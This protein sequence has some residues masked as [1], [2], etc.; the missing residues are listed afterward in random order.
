M[1]R[2]GVAG[3]RTRVG[4]TGSM[5]PLLLVG[6]PLACGSPPT[7][8]PMFWAL[9]KQGFVRERDAP[10]V[11]Q[12]VTEAD[13]VT[14]SL[15]TLYLK[16]VADQEFAIDEL[17]EVRQLLVYAEVYDSPE[18]LD[19]YRTVIFDGDVRGEDI[20]VD[21]V[22]HTIYGPLPFTGHPLRVELYVV[23]LDKEGNELGAKV[24]SSIGTAASVAQPQAAPA[25]GMGVQLGQV[26]L[27]FNKDDQEL[28]SKM[29]FHPA[30]IDAKVSR[31]PERDPR[32]L[33]LPSDD[34]RVSKV[35]MTENLFVTPARAGN[36]LLVKAES[37]KRRSRTPSQTGP[38]AR[39]LTPPEKPAGEI[40]EASA[41]RYLAV[42]YLTDDSSGKTVYWVP[43][44]K[45][46]YMWWWDIIPTDPTETPDAGGK[47][48][49]LEAGPQG[50]NW[51][52]GDDG[53][54]YTSK[55]YAVLAIHTGGKIADAAKIRAVSV[56]QAQRIQALLQAG[57]Q[58]ALLSSVDK[59]G[60]SAAAQLGALN[61]LEDV[62]V[63]ART[64]PG[65]RTDPA[66]VRELIQSLFDSDK[67]NVDDTYAADSNRAVLKM[68]RSTM[69]DFEL[70][71]DR[72]ADQFLKIKPIRVEAKNAAS[73]C[74]WRDGLFLWKPDATG[75]RADCAK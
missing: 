61:I 26:L 10:L 36:Y 69:P 58:Q 20:F 35:P 24:L 66:F 39:M 34:F 44:Y 50:C 12:Y 9:D 42:D 48:K 60:Q 75:R 64:V 41:R 6:G 62:N 15:N 1:R 16:Y 74:T 4:I 37:K 19:P 29:T 65:Y 63:R 13:V 22:D 59:L 18:S 31:D 67:G 70:W 52:W 51:R 46:G 28:T 7:G 38:N 55:S 21:T 68:I 72:D 71:P 2:R 5:L 3:Q 17:G 54:L 33:G 47:P 49:C 73:I 30:S 45:A 56:K 57:D 25:I 53:T 11:G 14:V 8:S 40:A 32:K 43:I 23:E 27:S